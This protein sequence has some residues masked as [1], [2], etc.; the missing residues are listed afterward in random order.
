MKA[1]EPVAKN[2][3]DKEAFFRAYADLAMEQERRY[4]IPAAKPPGT[5]A[6][7]SNYGQSEPYLYNSR[8]KQRLP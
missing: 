6:L 7:E 2:Q 8:I 5:L 1:L 4:G 3:E